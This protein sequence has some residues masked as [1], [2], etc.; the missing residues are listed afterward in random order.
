MK[1]ILVIGGAGYIG[2]ACVKLLCVAGYSVLVVD[3]LSTGN[4][5]AID[6]RATFKKFDILQRKSFLRFLKGEKIDVII[7]FAAH[8]NANESMKNGTQYSENIQ[9]MINV[10]DGMIN[11][12]IPKVIFSSSAAVYG[13]PISLPINE[14][15]SL[16]PVNYYGETKLICERLIQWYAQIYQIS[17]TI[18]RYF[19]VVG[20][21]GLK[22]KEKNAHNLFPVIN[23]VIQGNQKYLEVFGKNYKTKDGTC[24]RDYIHLEDIANAHLSAINHQHSDIFNIGTSKGYSVLEIIQAFEKVTNKK[25]PKKFI[26]RKRGDSPSAIADAKKANKHLNWQAK[27]NLE[28]MVKSSLF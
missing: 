8:K 15:H 24:I 12:R 1:K 6:K 21:I 3:N 22:Y 16:Q 19:N 14:Q 17:F 2:S 13:D 28:E 27:R 26:K 7:H 5:E 18:L 4:K 10:L 9:G 23:N 20:D 11:N 25:I